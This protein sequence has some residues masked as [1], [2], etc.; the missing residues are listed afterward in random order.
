MMYIIAWSWGYPSENSHRKMSK[1]HEKTSEIRSTNNYIV[2]PH[3]IVEWCG[4]ARV[5]Y[6]CGRV[7]VLFRH[8]KVVAFNV[9]RN[10]QIDMVCLKMGDSRK[11]A[12]EWKTW[13][14][15]CRYPIFRQ[16]QMPNLYPMDL[17]NIEDPSFPMLSKSLGDSDIFRF[18][19]WF[20]KCLDP[21]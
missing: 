17:L 7:A 20:P 4:I 3:Y 10:H 21:C 5:I 19:K 18:H 11:M 9:V 6:I 2:C 14:N 8:D 12:I 16:T 13:W 15:V 1:T